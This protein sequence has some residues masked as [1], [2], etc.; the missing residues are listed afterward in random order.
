MSILSSVREIGRAQAPFFSL[1][2]AM[3]LV[4]GTVVVGVDTLLHRAE[5]TEQFE[6]MVCKAVQPGPIVA[7]RF[8][9]NHA[10]Q[11][12]QY[13]ALVLLA[14][15]KVSGSGLASHIH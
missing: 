3:A 13:F 10:P 8:D 11:Q 14:E 7:G 4:A 2:R 5:L 9:L 1:G 12:R 15:G 6:Q